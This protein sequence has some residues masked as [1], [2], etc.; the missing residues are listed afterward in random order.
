MATD[1]ENLVAALN[2]KIMFYYI[3]LTLLVEIICEKSYV[4]SV[5]IKKEQGKPATYA[6]EWRVRFKY[7]NRPFIKDVF[8]FI[9]VAQII[10]SEIF[11]Y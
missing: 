3:N 2:I 10:A 11:Y 4:W 9:P 6:F 1:V 5:Y 7:G 8:L